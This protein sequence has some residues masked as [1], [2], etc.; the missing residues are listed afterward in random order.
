MMVDI[1]SLFGEKGKTMPFALEDQWTPALIAKDVREFMSPVKVKGTVT[2]QEDGYL[3]QAEGETEL[4]LQ[5]D[6]GLAPVPYHITFGLEELF[7]LTGSNKEK[8]TE[9]FSGHTIDLMAAVERSI[10]SALPMKVLCKEDCKGICPKCGKDLNEGDCDCTESN[11]DPR[12]ESLRALF[13][14]DKEV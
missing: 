4:L 7:A 14:L 11:I 13:Q 10:A 2:N 1:Q 8:E 9:T 3:V 6:R 12:F 5:R